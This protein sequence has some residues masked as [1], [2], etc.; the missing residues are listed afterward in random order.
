MPNNS[1][2]D[3][4]TL[5]EKLGGTAAVAELVGVKSPS[6]SGWKDAQRIPDDKLIRLASI[7][8]KRGIA[9]RKELFPNDY[10]AIWPELAPVNAK[11]TELRKARNQRDPNKLSLRAGEHEILMSA[12]AKAL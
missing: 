2:M 8:E 3:A 5:I 6:V 10:A 7:A 1:D 11:G 9:T 12:K 4:L